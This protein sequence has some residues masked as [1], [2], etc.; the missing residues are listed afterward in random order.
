M[1]DLPLR[2]AISLL[3]DGGPQ[4]C[5]GVF[6]PSHLGVELQPRRL[7]PGGIAPPGLTG[8]AAHSSDA[9]GTVL[10]LDDAG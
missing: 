3:F 1:Q 5:L 2:A 9:R 7:E 8:A 4:P 6:K 10:R